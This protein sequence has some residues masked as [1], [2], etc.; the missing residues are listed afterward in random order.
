MLAHQT[1]IAYDEVAEFTLIYEIVLVEKMF[2]Y[3]DI[4]FESC[5]ALLAMVMGFEQVII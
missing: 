3:I 2:D 4:G 5:I 1:L